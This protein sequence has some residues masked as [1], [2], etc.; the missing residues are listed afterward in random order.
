MARISADEIDGGQIAT[1]LFADTDYGN[2]GL[3]DNSAAGSFMNTAGYNAGQAPIVP[4]APAAP[5]APAGSTGSSVP[6][7]STG[8]TWTASDGTVFTDQGAFA[9]YAAGL[10]TANAAAA[11]A[12]ATTAAANTA[13]A[14]AKAAADAQAALDAANKS[15]NQQNAK[16]LLDSTLSGYGLQNASTGT[17]I[18]DAILGLV[19]KNY[20]APTIQALIEDPASAKSSD[21]SVAA[22][23]KAW[24]ARFAGN[25][26]PNGRIAQGLSP[27]SPSEYIATE[28]S[29]NNIIQ[30]SGLPKGFYDNS[31]HFAS[32][33]AGGVAPTELQDRINTASK[34]ILNQDP[35]YTSTLQQYYGLT[36]GD[37]IAHALD[38]NV[39]LP[40]LQRATATATFGAAGARQNVNV[41]Q[42]TAA[43]YAALGITQGQAEQGFQSVAQALPTEQKLAAIYGG[44]KTQF[45]S[46]GQQ[47]ANLTAATFGG[48]GG[49][50][51]EAQ[52]KKLQQQEV[53]AFSGSSGVDKNSLF[54]STSGTF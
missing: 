9:T 51:A 18:S 19:Q 23:A 53:N 14:T 24:D 8:K 38:P 2:R 27:L 5:A 17:A 21:P 45:G 15:I 4:P 52:L 1:P 43:Q 12:A 6:L 48:A 25:Y 36:P 31:Q 50:Q 11:T 42:A 35:F 28:N 32:L 41:D 54:G 30:A 29:Y 10:A 47:Q 13:A 40:L 3:T 16:Q 22:L 20:D 44:D 46:A 37:M 49:A 26:G 39:A 7:G 34:S 33:I